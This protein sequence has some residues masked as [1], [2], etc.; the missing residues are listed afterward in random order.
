MRRRP[1]AE[2]LPGA[3]APPADRPGTV[4]VGPFAVS[5]LCAEDLVAALVDGT[6]A[7]R[8]RRP[9]TAYALHVGGL[10]DRNEPAFVAAM[11]RADLVYADGM[12]VVLLA[13]L[14]GATA[15]DRCGTTDLGWSVLRALA[16]ALGRPVRL[17]L[18]G[19]PPGLSAAAGTA[20]EAGAPVQVVAA[21]HGYSTD[22]TGVLERLRNARP[23]VVVVGL[24]APREMLWVDEHL[25]ELPPALVL[26]CGGWFGFLTEAEKR[27]PLWMQSAG[28]EWSYRVAQAPQRLAGRYARGLGT[29][30]L[31][32]ARML[33]ARAGRSGAGSL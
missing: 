21:E 7:A 3:G 24:G 11:N 14:A 5:D 22:W 32:A 15:M 30:G 19:G 8:G 12:S 33:R 31:L 6:V 16:A 17:A 26:T 4:P 20:L 23:D 1:E 9:F 10:N 18:V 29:T 13:R 2:P 28:L 25:T 27:A